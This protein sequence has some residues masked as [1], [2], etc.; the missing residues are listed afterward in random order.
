MLTVTKKLV[1]LLTILTLLS[2]TFIFQSCKKS[3]SDMGKTLFQKTKNKVFKDVTPEGFAEV[4]QK[5]LTDERSKL[6]YPQVIN[7]YYAQ[8]GYDPMFVMDHVFNT[9]LKT[10]VEYYRKANEHGLDTNLF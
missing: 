3:R 5:V 8:N 7:A 2:F 9:D 4:F 6:T 1:K 10:S